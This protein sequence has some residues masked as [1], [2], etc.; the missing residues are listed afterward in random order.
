[1]VNQL[2]EYAT[3]QFLEGEDI[4][5]DSKHKKIGKKLKSLMADVKKDEVSPAT[6]DER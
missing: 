5:S 4:H 6:F 2:V 1:M 3:A